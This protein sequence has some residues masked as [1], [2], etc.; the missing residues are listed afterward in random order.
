[1]STSNVSTDLDFARKYLTAE[2]PEL[3]LSEA[4]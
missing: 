1:M 2:L 3:V 4:N